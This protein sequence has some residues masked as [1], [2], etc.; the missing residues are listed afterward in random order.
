MTE[1]KRLGADELTPPQGHDRGLLGRAHENRPILPGGPL[2]DVLQRLDGIHE[3]LTAP[4]GRIASLDARLDSLLC[5]MRSIASAV[6]AMEELQ[7]PMVPTSR[8]LENITVLIV[9]DELL[10][11][12]GLARVLYSASAHTVL[13]RDAK[14]AIAVLAT[15]RVGVAL[16]DLRL[17]PGVNGIALCRHIREHHPHVG[18]VIMTGM[19]LDADAE[20]AS[21]LR[22]RILEK[23]AH[24]VDVIA[25]IKE[26]NERAA[27][28][29]DHE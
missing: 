19:V 28:S 1:S 2:A 8:D 6:M 10:V 17:A 12:K 21:D 16:V 29:A 24:N 5:G 15:S 4:N 3:L 22:I 27:T 25:A 9:D 23:P 14:E 13:A 18:I 11:Q 7:A 20:A 26:A